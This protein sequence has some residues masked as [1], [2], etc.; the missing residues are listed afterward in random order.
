MITALLLGEIPT[1][2][3]VADDGAVVEPAHAASS[4]SNVTT[5]TTERKSVR[6]GS[7]LCPAAAAQSIVPP[8]PRAWEKSRAVGVIGE[9]VR[10]P[11]PAHPL[12]A[13]ILET[14]R[15]AINA[16]NRARHE[17]PESIARVRLRRRAEG[18]V[19]RWCKPMVGLR[20]K[21]ECARARLRPACAFIRG[22]VARILA[23]GVVTPDER[24]ELWRAIETVLPPDLCVPL[25]ARRRAQER[26]DVCEGR[27][28]D[29]PV[30]SWNLMVAGCR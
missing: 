20:T 7:S 19:A 24:R 30:G 27:E 4:I 25:T 17:T 8:N 16:V 18:R 21:L 13:A 1:G 22:T 26:R 9:S 28:R 3:P 14:T 23:D 2:V 11:Q 29:Q 5:A 6:M 10:S 15:A 12:G